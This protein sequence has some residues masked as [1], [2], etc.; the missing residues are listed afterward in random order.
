MKIKEFFKKYGNFVSLVSLLILT[1]ISI[2][3]ATFAW[4]ASNS[5]D[6]GRGI[7]I[8]TNEANVN[9][10]DLIEIKRYFDNSTDV[11]SDKWYHRYIDSFYYE[12]DIDT[13]SYVI[14][15]DGNKISM[16]IL[17]LYP[18]EYV[19][20]QM[21]YK[22]TEDIKNKPY[23]ITLTNFDDSNGIFTE[24]VD[25]VTYSHSALGVFRVGE[26][27]L[28]E[29]NNK[30]VNSWS[31]LA[32]YNGDTQEDTK[33]LSVIVKN[34]DFSNEETVTIDNEEYYTATFRLQLSFL[35]YD[36]LKYTATNV[37]SN[38]SIYIN[39]INLQILT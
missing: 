37:L 36:I 19:D 14:D 21:W 25:N 6:Y 33:P 5:I 12:Y 29:S 35:Q 10:R 8:N 2:I 23:T 28:D 38:K 22:V 11:T 39:T 9:F 27:S 15:D 30:V 24:T 31:W 4:F 16:D 34:G 32:T 20:V 17:S 13:N 1:V 26:V 7:N 3:T 18:N